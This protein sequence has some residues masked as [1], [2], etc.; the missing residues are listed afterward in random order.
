MLVLFQNRQF[1]HQ[2]LVFE[3]GYFDPG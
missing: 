2:A 3:A 1:L